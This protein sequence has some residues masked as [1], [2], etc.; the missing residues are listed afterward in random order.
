MD[1][2]EIER[3]KKQLEQC[4]K[5]QRKLQAKLIQQGKYPYG[6]W[7]EV[8]FY[9]LLFAIALIGVSVLMGVGFVKLRSIIH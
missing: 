9:P 6:P 2:S 7:R 4:R 5:Q 1:T 3:L 8:L